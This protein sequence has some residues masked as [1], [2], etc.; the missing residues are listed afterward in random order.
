MA[1]PLM[2]RA[3]AV[4]AVLGLS[5][6]QSPLTLY[7]RMRGEIP[8][9]PDN[10]LLKEGRYFEDAIARIAADKFGFELRQGLDHPVGEIDEGMG[11]LLTDGEIL[12]GHPDRYFV[13]DGKVGVLE[14][15]QTRYG[16]VGH[17]G[18]GDPGTDQVP[19]DY[20][21]QV[22]TYIYLAMKN[23]EMFDLPVAD[24]GLLA[25][26]MN[27]GTELYKIQH[28]KQVIEKVREEC[29]EFV[30]RVKDGNPPDPQDEADA[31]NRWAVREKNPIGCDIGVVEQLRQ[32]TR[33][34]IQE[35][36]I[37][38][39][40]SEMQT[41]IFCY[42]QDHDTIVYHDENGAERVVATVGVN[43]KF[44]AEECLQNHPDLLNNYATLD[45]SKLRKENRK[46]YDA[47]SRKPVDP[48]EQTRVLR[49][50]EKAL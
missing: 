15:K 13:I 23:P 44:N 4:G 25:A 20:W 12:N 30:Q 43:R 26:H 10:E 33:L 24:Y 35:K 39:Q 41:A 29:F 34:K 40:I 9:Q 2:I 36:A 6:F 19:D 8:E 49:I 7:H 47:Y 31:R 32:L 5:K 28:D 18:W 3:S 38:S 50:K 11:W 27:S 22:Q 14:I 16:E 46:L 1:S 48:I 17:G 37:R 42:A 45:T 21:F